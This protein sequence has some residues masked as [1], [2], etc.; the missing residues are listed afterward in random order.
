M[1]L[2]WGRYDDKSHEIS[3]EPNENKIYKWPGLDYSNVRIKDFENVSNANMELIDRIST[4]R[5]PWHDVHCLLEGPVV[6]DIC[7]HF[8]ERW[9]FS[10]NNVIFKNTKKKTIVRGIYYK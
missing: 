3:E 2:C 1:D 5:M 6:Y 4:P 8:I 7:R 10:I 9:N